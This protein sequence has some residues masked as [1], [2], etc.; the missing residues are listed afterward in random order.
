MAHDSTSGPGQE[1]QQPGRRPEHGPAREQGGTA[2]T[3]RPARSGRGGGSTRRRPGRRSADGRPRDRATIR[4][5]LRRE[6]P[7]TVGVLADTADFRAMRRYPS[8][9]FDDHPEYLRETEALLRVLTSRQPHTVLA[10]FDPEDFAA[11]CTEHALD[12]DSPLSRARYT[13]QIP[14]QG[15]A[16]LYGGEPLDSLLPV[17]IDT[18]VRHATW[19]YA[20]LLLADIGQCADCGEDIGEASFDR[21]SRLLLALLE[22][23]GPGTHHLVC[24][25]AAPAEQLIAAFHTD[26][27]TDGPDDGGPPERAVLDAPGAAEFVTVLAAAIALGRPGG[28]VLRTRTPGSPDR[29]HGWRIHPRGL[30]PLSEAEVFNA[31]CTDATTGEPISPEPGVDYRAGFPVPD[32]YPEA[33]H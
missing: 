4:S 9:P 22:A 26:D 19:E 7:G 31:Y 15:A 3:P 28:L 23:A 20:S 1:P 16:V 18:A 12:P 33:H 17:L 6:A 13:A 10:L 32:D 25:V 27:P 24:S 2:A 5:A 29:L 11:Y 8:F 21:A 14:A 30:H